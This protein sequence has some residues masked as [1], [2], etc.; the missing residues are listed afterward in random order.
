MSCISENCNRCCELIL[1]PFC[2]GNRER[3]KKILLDAIEVR[4]KKIKTQQHEIDRLREKVNDLTYA[5]YEDSG[6]T[7]EEVQELAKAKA[8]GRLVVL[9]CKPND[10][11]WHRNYYTGKLELNVE[12]HDLQS[13]D[14]T[15]RE[16]DAHAH[17]E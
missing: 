10:I 16:I 2:D 11:Y 1:R 3:C 13:H 17:W 6:L 8:E 15:Y 14:E 7:P 5:T 9:P 12:M 4:N